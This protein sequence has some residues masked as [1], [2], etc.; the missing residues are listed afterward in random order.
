M[1]AVLHYFFL[2]TA[3]ILGILALLH[4]GS[5]LQ[6]PASIGGEWHLELTPSAINEAGC[7][8]L[9]DPAVQ[10]SL[11]ILQSG[12]HLILELNIGEEM[13]LRG[14]LDNLAITTI[15]PDTAVFQ[16]TVD[17]QSEP[18]RLAGNLTFPNCGQLLTFTGIRQRH[19]VKEAGG[20]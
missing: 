10:P 11:E 3:P 1:K 13:S 15:Q 17:R 7:A 2:V 4:L 20:H 5:R 16:A 6:A 18:D 14:R 8:T 12:T 9:L 19:I